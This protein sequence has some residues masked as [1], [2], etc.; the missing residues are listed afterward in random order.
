MSGHDDGAW[1]V[2]HT[3][4]KKR[5]N[6]C[7]RVFGVRG[8]D[9]EEWQPFFVLQS[10]AINF[11]FWSVNC[12]NP[13]CFA[14]E[15]L[16]S[17]VYVFWIIAMTTISFSEAMLVRQAVRGDRHALAE[18]YAAH[19]PVLFRFIVSRT[20]DF[21]KAEDLC[22]EVFLRMLEGISSYEDRGFPFSAWLFRIA[23]DRIVDD[24]RRAMRRPTTI[25]HQSL[26]S[27]D[28]VENVVIDQLLLDHVRRI[29]YKLTPDQRQV[30]VLRFFDRLSI[31]DVADQMERS[32]A[33][34]KALQQRAVIALAGHLG[35]RS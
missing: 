6:I 13:S 20:G 24:R 12:R 10:Q 35:I 17:V 1:C 26:A 32:E 34:V 5:G 15:L 33:S 9:G 22:S 3:M 28:D 14:I 11:F 7:F 16:H 2:W 27:A 25:L 19:Q 30:I 18:I 31:A 8:C 23:R 21:N 4:P 29:L